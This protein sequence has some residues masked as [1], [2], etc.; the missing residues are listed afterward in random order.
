M[1][2]IGIQFFIGTTLCMSVCPAIAAPKDDIAVVESAEP[3]DGSNI[4]GGR[5][6]YAINNS[7]DTRI[8][9]TIGYDTLPSGQSFNTFDSTL[10][11]ATESYPK[12]FELRLEPKEKHIAGCSKVFRPDDSINSLR[13]IPIVATVVGAAVAGPQA[14]E[15][16][17]ARNYVSFVIQRRSGACPSGNKPAGRYFGI[18][19]HPSRSISA[20]IGT[21]KRSELKA[22]F[23]ASGQ[24]GPMTCTNGDFVI[25]GVNSAKYTS[26]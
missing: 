3:C 6:I 7:A 8:D 2:N 16:G 19:M 15:V 10:N 13:A 23:A 14:P 4:V 21:T 17:P 20:M 1:R 12:T 18:S 11:A 26:N 9:A 25:T 5:K 22:D 24:S